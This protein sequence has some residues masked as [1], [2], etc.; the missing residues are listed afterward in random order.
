[1]SRDFIA[2]FKQRVRRVDRLEDIPAVPIKPREPE[3]D[4]PPVKRFNIHKRSLPVGIDKIVVFGVTRAEAEWWIEFKLKAKVYQD[5]P[6]DSKTVIYYDLVPVDATPKERNIYFNAKPT[7][8]GE[9]PEFRP[10]RRIN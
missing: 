10:P 1:M 5:E 4:G 7:I 3:S 2:E 9:F 8:V 6:E